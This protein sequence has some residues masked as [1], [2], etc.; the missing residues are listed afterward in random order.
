MPWDPLA[1][2]D[3]EGIP[4]VE[5]GPNVAR[6]RVAI[7]CPLC[8]DDP[9]E[10]LGVVVDT[11]HPYFG[12]WGC[13][14][15][16]RHRGASPNYL[17]RVLTGWGKEQIEK[18][19]ENAPT[20]GASWVD[21]GKRLKAA[22]ERSQSPADRAEAERLSFPP[23]FRKI[24]PYGV[25]T[26]FWTYMLGR[27]FPSGDLR[28]VCATYRLR[29]AVTGDQKYRVV[30]PFFH[31]GRC[32]GWSGRAIGKAQVRYR[33]FPEGPAAKRHIPDHL[34]RKGGKV[35]CLVEGP[36]DWIKLDFYG[37]KYGVRAIPCLGVDLQPGQIRDIFKLMDEFDYLVI[38]L[39]AA[40]RG[41]AMRMKGDLA[42]LRPRTVSPPGKDPGALSP[43]KARAFAKHLLSICGEKV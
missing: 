42:E 18:Y 1:F 39:D 16:P 23:E 9:S 2:F 27:G 28:K 37:Q 35:L 26:R 17:I 19:L 3:S 20:S 31:K 15:D 21:L 43:K 36:L 14:R 7:K 13:L 32:Y 22:D 41:V 34:A 29:C 38:V 4:Y 10:H 8:S 40:A 33:T 25:S 6:G 30:I 11:D 12:S 24:R 5:R